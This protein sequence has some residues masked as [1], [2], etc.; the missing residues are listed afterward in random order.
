MLSF[1]TVFSANAALNNCVLMRN[2]FPVCRCEKI[3]KMQFKKTQNATK[4]GG[5]L[6]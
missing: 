1:N 2:G 4:F 6:F 5:K 3:Q